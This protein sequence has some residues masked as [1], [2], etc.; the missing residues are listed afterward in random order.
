M[1]RFL[2][3]LLPLAFVASAVAQTPTVTPNGIVNSASFAYAGLPGGA[4]APGSLFVVFGSNLGPTSLSQASSYPLPTSLSGTSV[5]VTVGST[6]V[7]AIMVYTVASQIAAVLPSSTPTGAGNLVVTYNGKSSAASSFQ[8]AASNFGVFTSNQGGSGPGIIADANSKVFGSTSPAK[9]GQTAVIWGTGLGAVGGNE[10]GGPLPGDLT[11][12]PVEVYVGGQK[13]TV[14]YRGRSGC[15]AGVDQISFTVPSVTGCRV[16]VSLKINN[17]VSNYSTMPIAAA[18][19]SACSDVGGPST[20]DLQRYYAQGS[21]AI[22]GIS[23]VRVSS[24]LAVPFLGTV[25]TSADLGSATFSKYP[26]ALLDTAAN[27]FNVVT[28]GSCSVNYYKGTSAAVADIV[29]PTPLD[30]GA[31]ITVSGPA[32]TKQLTKQTFGGYQQYSGALGTSTFGSS[33]PGFLDPGTLT[34]SGPGGTDVKAFSTTVNVPQPLVWTNQDSIGPVSRSAGTTVTWTGGDPAGF[35]FIG[36]LSANGSASDSVG[37]SFSCYAKPTDGKFT[38]PASVLL[39]LPVTTTVSGV[40]V[41]QMV[42]GSI[43]AVKTFNVTG[44]DTAFVVTTV[45]VQKSLSFQ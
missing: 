3:A 39:A 44:L 1:K 43:S 37:A 24:S 27:P 33:G 16:P 28:T 35:V 41:G 29:L 38:I 32:G 11:S 30:A 36:G 40:P 25:T 18:G 14:T 17:S 31:A 34:I 42:I 45:D 4:I 20:T 21:V 26:A 15:C 12:V 9:I 13:A 10:A 8:I 7:N 19:A 22:G 5:R 23:L 6:S 2:T